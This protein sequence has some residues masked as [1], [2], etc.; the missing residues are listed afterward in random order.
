[1]VDDAT[2]K[3]LGGTKYRGET[4][5]GRREDFF[6]LR[7]PADRAIQNKLVARQAL[8]AIERLARPAAPGRP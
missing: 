6:F 1:M 3:T 8:R 4:I 5:D 7:D 2:G